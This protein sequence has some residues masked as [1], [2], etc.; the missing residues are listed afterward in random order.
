[1]GRGARLIVSL[2]VCCVVAGGIAWWRLSIP[3]KQVISL[4]A[5][6][7]VQALR[8]AA[9]RLSEQQQAEEDAQA[10]RRR[11][12]NYFRKFPKQ[13]GRKL[14]GH[15]DGSLDLSVSAD[16][17][18]VLTASVD[19]TARLWDGHKLLRMLSG[20]EGR[21]YSCALSPDGKRAAA[22]GKDQYVIV[23]DADTAEVLAVLPGHIPSVQAMAFVPDGTLLTADRRGTLRRWDV[24]KETVVAELVGHSQHVLALTVSRDGSR[25]YSADKANALI[26]WDL[27]KN[28]AAWRTTAEPPD[29]QNAT[30]IVR[31]QLSA[32]ERQFYVQR[33][34]RTIELW[35][36]ESGELV[37]TIDG[38]KRVMAM[39]VHPDGKHVFVADVET[40]GLFLWTLG[41]EQVPAR[42]L[43]AFVAPFQIHDM[44]FGPN[45]S[46][47]FVAQGGVFNNA[48][49]D[50]WQE[51]E[52]GAVY[53][54]DLDAGATEAGAAAASRAA[55]P[56]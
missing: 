17:S 54:F 33:F 13:Q 14:I 46:M 11:D 15:T 37:R 38:P 21:L 55:L 49:T 7:N 9:V 12:P 5:D 23:W 44:A 8:D 41:S 48:M 27:K 19:G 32:D 3:L 24:G 18:R 29:K 36:A 56:R 50:G 43:K 6:P 28:R 20:H 2:L 25:A 52:E 34:M 47:L 26:C 53:V 16:G 1:V 45:E 10:E 22:G 35:D 31:I 42:P 39:L 4:P 30:D 51:A 40:N